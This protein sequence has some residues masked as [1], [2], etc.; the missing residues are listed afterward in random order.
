MR[1]MEEQGGGQIYN[2]EGWGSDGKRRIVNILGDHP[3]T[4][5]RYLV[6]KILS[7][8]RNHAHFVWLTGAKVM[9]RFLT[10]PFR[11]GDLFTD[12]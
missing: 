2:L 10:A 5:A 8:G 3:E 6:R 11:K 7:N 4:V 9:S 1:G 12:Y